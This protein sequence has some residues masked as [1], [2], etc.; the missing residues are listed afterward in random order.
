M[1]VIHSQNEISKVENKELQEYLEYSF[2]RM[3]TD[4]L[5]NYKQNGSYFV[6]VESWS[7]LTQK[8]IKI[9]EWEVA[10]IESD[11]FFNCIELV[12]VRENI[13]EIL[14]QFSTDVS[15]GLV[16]EMKILP[17]HVQDRLMKHEL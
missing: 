14:L 2:S 16:L 10:S 5:E 4:I 7:E 15:L 6:V 12:E 13:M 1:I 11:E 9:D 8:S 3:P 17:V